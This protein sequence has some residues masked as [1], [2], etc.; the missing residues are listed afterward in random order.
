M[1]DS[2]SLRRLC[3]LQL[4]FSYAHYPLAHF[5]ASNGRNRPTAAGHDQSLLGGAK[6]VGLDFL[7]IIGSCPWYQLVV[8]RLQPQADLKN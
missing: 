3:W 6:P 1:K 8:V 2:T 4:N 5:R 7:F